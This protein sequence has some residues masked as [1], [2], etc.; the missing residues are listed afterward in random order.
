MSVDYYLLI[1]TGLDVNAEFLI[2][3]SCPTIAKKYQ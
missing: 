1:S 3:A 2:Y